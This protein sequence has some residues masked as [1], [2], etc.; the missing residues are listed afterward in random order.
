MAKIK[1]KHPSWF[2]LKVERR[3]LIKTLEPTVAVNVLLACLDYLV[4]RKLPCTLTDWE[5]AIFSLLLP[6]VEE[7]W[8]TYSARVENGGMGGAPKGNKNA[9]KEK[10]GENWIFTQDN[11]KMMSYYTPYSAL[12][13][14]LNHY[15]ADKAEA[16]KLPM[17]PFHGLRHTKATLQIAAGTDVRTVSAILGHRETSTTMNIYSH[18]LQTAEQEAAN[19]MEKLLAKQA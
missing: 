6:D 10:Q 1:G 16:D 15:N 17:I 7:A 14:I 8:C 3:E 11:G 13:D 5:K 2:K 19:K 4:D 18:S 12:Q 9:K